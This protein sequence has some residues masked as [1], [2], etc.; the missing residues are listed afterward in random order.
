MAAERHR[1]SLAVDA[2]LHE[3][4]DRL[5][6]VV[7]M[8]LGMEAEDGAS[9]QSVDDLIPPGTDAEGLRVWP[10]NVPEGDDRRARQAPA[11]HARQQGEVIVLHQ[12]DRVVAVRLLDDD[13]GEALI[14][15]DVMRPVPLAERRP[16][17]GDMAKRP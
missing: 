1:A 11:K 12:D 13:V 14:D 17:E 9:E 6:E 5:D 4:V 2:A 15:R 16:H 7:A 3:A 8:E 10:R